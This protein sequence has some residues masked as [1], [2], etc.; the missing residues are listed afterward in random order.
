MYRK[1]RHCCRNF[2]VQLNLPGGGI[3][4]TRFIL[5]GKCPVRD[6]A[7]SNPVRAAKKQI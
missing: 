1:M 4:Q 6:V 3:G 5:D 2:A 7:G